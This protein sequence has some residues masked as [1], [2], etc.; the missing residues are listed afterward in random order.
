MK[1]LDI[2]FVS[3]NEYFEHLSALIVSILMNSTDDEYHIFH[4]VSSI[5][6]IENKKS[7]EILKNIKKFDVFYYEQSRPKYNNLYSDTL[8]ENIH[9]YS[10]E[11]PG[12]EVFQL[13]KHLDKFLYLD[14][15][16][17]VNT[18]LSYLFDIDISNYYI[19]FAERCDDGAYEGYKK[20][21]GLKPHHKYFNVG[22]Y[23]INNKLCLENNIE[24]EFIKFQTKYKAKSM[25]YSQDGL[26]YFVRDKVKIVDKTWNTLQYYYDDNQN[27]KIIHFNGPSKPWNANY[28]LPKLSQLYW[29][30]FSHTLF[31]KN[32]PTKYID[33]MIKQNIAKYEY[34]HTIN[35]NA[36]NDKLN[37]LIDYIAWW[38]PIRKWR[39][40]FRAKF[41]MHN[42]PE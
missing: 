4:I 10:E 38:I 29:K 5:I 11:V 9:A 7:I 24:E 6:N 42:R 8:T 28:T 26:N 36:I 3:S 14:S 40:N 12:I 41:K 18:S 25:F 32:N 22:V 15:D 23:L 30:Y 31:F 2:V 17:I 27:T 16:I 1:R 20:E 21:I 39:E 35:C 37:K 33:I 19:I 34:D 13:L